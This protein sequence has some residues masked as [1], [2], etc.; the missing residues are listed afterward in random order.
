MKT[1]ILLLF[2]I[3][4]SISFSQKS[5]NK[6]LKSLNKNSVPY[7]SVQELSQLH[8]PLILDARKKN[9]FEVIHIKKCSVCRF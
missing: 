7:I 8:N 2:L 9:E 1:K 3:F 6:V 4:S 5:I